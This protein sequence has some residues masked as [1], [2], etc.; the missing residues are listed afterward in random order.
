MNKLTKEMIKLELRKD[1][2]LKT[3]TQLTKIYTTQELYNYY[4]NLTNK[5]CEIC[6]KETRFKNFKLGYDKVCSRSCRKS[7]KSKEYIPNFNNILEIEELKKFL[8]KEY[9]S[10]NTTN[11]LNNSFFINN[12]YI[13]ELNT[14]LYYMKESNISKMSIKLIYDFIFGCSICEK[15][16]KHTTFI[17]F[18]KGYRNSC[19]NCSGT[20]H[21]KNQ[22][23]K[24]YVL[25]NFIN[26]GKF[27]ADKMMKYHNVSYSFVNKW[28]VKNNISIE[29]KHKK[30]SYG[31][32]LL[33]RTYIDKFEVKS[34]S[35]NIINPSE[36]DI[37]IDD[38]LCIEYD[39]LL[40]H[41]SGEGFPG[42]CSRRY[43]LDLI[44]EKY[45]LLTIFE[46]EFLDLNKQKI[47]F[48]IINE[49]LGL[50]EKINLDSYIIKNI[51]KEKIKEF[52]LDNSLDKY[53]ESEINLGLYLDEELYSV[54][55]FNRIKDKEYLIVNLA[56]KKNYSVDYSVLISYFE[57][58]H[59]PKSIE[60]YS[61]RRYLTE[62][63]GFNFIENTEPNKF[64]FKIN[65][66]KLFLD[67]GE[68]EEEMLKNNYRIIYDYGNSKI[69]KVTQYYE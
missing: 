10:V 45:E 22:V 56:T 6:Q 5:K 26:K 33:F 53:I 50:N 25:N 40:F 16:C 43:K 69:V 27:L 4:H 31:E 2:S 59:K 47:W 54:V 28:K 13:R 61:N 51:D 60:Y 14:I 35:R 9:S 39:G 66:N 63:K 30:Y 24:E 34:N 38:K 19:N 17:G 37:V 29:N 52:V 62:I 68:N 49:K 36:I 20:L 3:K 46:D 67:F 42:N 18:N 55:S 57:Q 32:E 23:E 15:C 7:L 8:L 12:N 41:S 48:S 65:E 11:K 1:G 21:I 58:D 44:P 64:F